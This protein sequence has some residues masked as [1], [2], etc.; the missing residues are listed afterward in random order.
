MKNIFI[1]LSIFFISSCGHLTPSRSFNMHKKQADLLSMEKKIYHT[2]KFEI[3][4]FQKILA[5]DKFIRIYIEGDGLSWINRNTIS[6]DPTPRQSTV[7]S[8]IQNDPY[9]NI[10]YLARPCQFVTNQNC[11]NKYWTSHRFS[12]EV[13]NSYK[14]I[15]NEISSKYKDA[16]KNEK[17]RFELIGYSGGAS[18]A[19]S[20]GEFRS[21]IISIITIAGNIDPNWLM[22]YHKVSKLVEPFEPKNGTGLDNVSQLHILG[23]NDQ[24][25]PIEI[26]NR[27]KEGFNKTSNI[28]FQL[29]E[30]SHSMNIGKKWT[31]ILSGFKN[32]E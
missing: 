7:F 18:I 9:P 27:Y 25:V 15:L 20:L 12:S 2:D 5:T 3:L 14:Q 17:I 31:E 13:V 30:G 19:L 22:E 26:M 11:S 28:R 1:I 29:I 23:T 10:I 8:L 4:S 32:R 6:E 24:V 16:N 21:D